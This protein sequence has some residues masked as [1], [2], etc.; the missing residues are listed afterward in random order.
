MK[1]QT[2]ITKKIDIME[3]LDF[4]VT[5]VRENIKLTKEQ[6]QFAY[7]VGFQKMNMEPVDAANMVLMLD[8]I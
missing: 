4:V 8:S 5:I 1:C 6:M 3:Y 2:I 7:V